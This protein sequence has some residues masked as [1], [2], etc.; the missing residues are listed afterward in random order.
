MHQ[1]RVWAQSSAQ[2]KGGFFVSLLDPST[3][4][5]RQEAFLHLLVRET[6]RGTRYR[7]LFTLCL[8]KPDVPDGESGFEK[9]I[10]A[11]LSTKVSEFVRATDLVG[12][13]PENLLG[14]LL[15]HTGYAEAVGVAERVREAI[16]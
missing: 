8:F 10:E 11:A 15:L 6:G 4:L 5:F 9:K 13:F 3:G 14:V 12:Q 1:I 7:A 2:G 16:R